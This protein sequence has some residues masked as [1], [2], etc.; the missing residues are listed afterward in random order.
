M[1][2]FKSNNNIFKNPDQD[3]VFNENFMDS[4]ALILPET[5]R[6]DYSRELK[7][8]D[9]DIWEVLYE[10]SGGIGVYASWCPYAEFYMIKVGFYLEKL[11]KGIET[12][13]GPGSSFLVY[14][15][16]KE[17]GINLYPKKIWIEDEDMWLY[18]KPEFKSNTILLK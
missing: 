2:I 17:L 4:E 16:S 1:P 7:I 18:K 12:Y 11:G 5:K 14:K 10:S 9:V 13:Y 3:E 8:E 15:R 6:W